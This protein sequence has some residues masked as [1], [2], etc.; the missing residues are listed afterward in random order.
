M[1]FTINIGAYDGTAIR[2]V[3]LGATVAFIELERETRRTVTVPN[4]LSSM[5]ATSLPDDYLTAHR[6]FA[7]GSLL[8]DPWE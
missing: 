4:S 1:R 3:P 6:L 7:F 5:V 2:K 8:S